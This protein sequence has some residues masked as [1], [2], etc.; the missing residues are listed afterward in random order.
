MLFVCL[1]D[2]SETDFC[3]YSIDISRSQNFVPSAHQSCVPSF[4]QLKCKP[5][6]GICFFIFASNEHAFF[7]ETTFVFYEK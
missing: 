3:H 7:S 1:F 6:A 2:V 5:D 4:A